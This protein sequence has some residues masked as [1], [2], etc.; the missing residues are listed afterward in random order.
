MCD[1]MNQCRSPGIGNCDQATGLCKCYANWKGADC[2]Y[3]AI[4]SPQTV[5][6]P[7]TETYNGTKTYY[8]SLETWSYNESYMVNITLGSKSAAGSDKVQSIPTFDIFIG[9]SS[10]VFSN[11]NRFNH[12]IGIMGIK[13]N[14]IIKSSIIKNYTGFIAAIRVNSFDNY[15]NVGHEYNI[16]IRSYRDLKPNKVEQVEQEV[17]EVR[18]LAQIPT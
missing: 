13:N 4:E 9:D 5:N 7:F 1:A 17:Q 15:N 18:Q 8:F 10:G 2:G 14:F 6:Q 11:P 12:D 3:L 16:S